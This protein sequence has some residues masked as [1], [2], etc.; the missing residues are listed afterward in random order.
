M[1]LLGED[2]ELNNSHVIVWITDKQK[3]LIDS[4]RELFPHSEHWFYL[5]H[6]FNNFKASHKGLMLKNLLW[7]ATKSTTK[8]G[9]TQF[10]ES[11]RIESET[12]Y[13]WLVTKR[14]AVEKWHHQIGPKVMK[15]V[16]RIMKDSSICNPEYSGNYV[17]QVK[18][19]GGEQFMVNIEQKECACNKW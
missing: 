1:E 18:E 7:G 6:F 17:Y 11:L 2:L 16:E 4:I 14:A 10:M 15:F 19:N 3:G 9:F 5:K 12:A 13:Q 8:Q